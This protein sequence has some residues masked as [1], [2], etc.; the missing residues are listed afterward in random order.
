[1]IVLAINAIRRTGRIHTL[2][3]ELAI[4][5][6]SIASHWSYAIQLSVQDEWDFEADSKI[7]LIV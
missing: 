7:G 4:G 6:E 2:R 3:Y 1:M 5:W